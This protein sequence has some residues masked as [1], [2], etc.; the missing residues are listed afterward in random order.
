MPAAAELLTALDEA[1]VSLHKL[2]TAQPEGSDEERLIELAL[3]HLVSAVTILRAS[4]LAGSEDP[5]GDLTQSEQGELS[6]GWPSNRL[7]DWA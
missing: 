6:G 5:P 2:Y 7:P 3:T 1:A 4:E